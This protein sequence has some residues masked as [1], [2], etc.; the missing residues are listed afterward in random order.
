[1]ASD[2]RRRINRFTASEK[3]IQYKANVPSYI[4][5][6]EAAIMEVLKFI[7]ESKAGYTKLAYPIKRFEAAGVLDTFNYYYF[8]MANARTAKVFTDTK[9]HPSL[10]AINKSYEIGLMDSA[11]D[12]TFNPNG[13]LTLADTLQILEREIGKYG[14]TRA[15]I[16]RA[17]NATFKVSLMPDVSRGLVNV[18]NEEKMKLYQ[19][20]RLYN[21]KSV[22]S[23]EYVTRSEALKLAMGASIARFNYADINPMA[24]TH[25]NGY[26]DETWV[27]YAKAIGITD[28]DIN[29]NNYNQ[30]ARYIDAIVYFE[31]CKRIFL[32]NKSVR[33]TVLSFKDQD[34]YT[35]KELA[36]LK[37]MVADGIITTLPENLNGY[38]SITKGQLNELVVN[39]AEKYNT[40]ALEG[41]TIVTDPAKFPSNADQYPYIIS[42][43]DKSVYE[44]SPACQWVN[45]KNAREL[46][47][48]KKLRYPQVKAWTESYFKSL[49]N[50]DYNTITEDGLRSNLEH[51]LIFKLND[52]FIKDYVKYVKDNEIKIEGNA[53]LQ[54]PIIHYDGTYYRARMKVTFKVIHSKT[55]DSLLY[56]D[57]LDSRKETYTKDNYEFYVDYPLTMALNS[58]NIFLVEA[59]LYE[60][61]LNV[62]KSGIVKE[63]YK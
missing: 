21:N 58:E 44:I 43:V 60:Y 9:G 56:F 57:W 46:Y 47:K 18:I 6:K 25:Y 24:T 48:S 5:I 12:K 16:A 28:E 20:D 39:F 14:I 41:D 59:R 29:I 31:N 11:T 22:D 40:I 4:S 19:F 26:Q 33:E 1:M 15:D 17:M 55:K 61:I 8:D 54:V 52:K 38:E 23:R 45:F 49:L 62:E 3:N 34:K 35:S 32:E 63:N 42:S 10:R 37:D 27:E 30:N 53:K 50:I 36:A 13:T 51:Y 2:E 7:D